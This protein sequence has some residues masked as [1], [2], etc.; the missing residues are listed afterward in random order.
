[1]TRLQQG[2]IQVQ[3]LTTPDCPN[4]PPTE[5]LVRETIATLAPGTR[6]ET[7]TIQDLQ[8]A[9]KLDFPGSPTVRVNGIDLQGKQAPTEPAFSCRIYEGVGVPPRW[10]VETALVR[11]QMPRDI[12]F[13]CVA[14]SARSQ[15]AEGLALEMVRNMTLMKGLE[16]VRVSSAGSHPDR[17]RP[18][19]VAALAEVGIDISDHISK[20]LEAI[21]LDSVDLVVTLCAEEICPTFPRPVKWLHWPLPDPAKV[22]GDKE[23]VAESF[24]NV[25]GELLERLETLLDTTE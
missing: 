24:R 5:E 19:A 16:H 1:M 14:N 11:E 4:G 21:D 7:I 6:M 20:G 12:L 13:M 2:R 15:M 17:V 3:I 22:E 8:M 10:M 25:R 18:E 9:R 23:A